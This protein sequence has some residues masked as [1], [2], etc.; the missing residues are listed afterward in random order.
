MVWRKGKG[1]HVNL[2]GW[3]ASFLNVEALSSFFFF[4]GRKALSSY[5]L[6]PRS[7]LFFCQHALFC[8]VTV[9][10]KSFFTVKIFFVK[11]FFIVK[12]LVQ[13]FLLSININVLYCLVFGLMKP[14]STN[15]LGVCL[16]LGFWR[17]G[18]RKIYSNILII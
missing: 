7:V 2:E 14:I 3:E 17:E 11:G 13:F 1:C 5:T 4:F 6:R 16:G 8:H 18:E 10:Q 15:S 9:I 12:F